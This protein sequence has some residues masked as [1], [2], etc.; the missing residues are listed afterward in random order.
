MLSRRKATG[1]GF[2]NS[3]DPEQTSNGRQ[4]LRPED[5]NMLLASRGAVPTH[6]PQWQGTG[7][8]AAVNGDKREDCFG[9]LDLLIAIV[10]AG[11]AST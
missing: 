6:S 9:H 3:I 8:G 7:T 5:P 4:A 11:Q 2:F 1:A 10:G